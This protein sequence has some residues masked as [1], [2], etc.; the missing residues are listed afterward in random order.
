MEDDIMGRVMA[1]FVEALY[2]GNIKEA[3]Y[4]ETIIRTWYGVPNWGP[5]DSYIQFHKNRMVR[6]IHNL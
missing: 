6:G 4:F 5:V 2:E 1:R 3:E